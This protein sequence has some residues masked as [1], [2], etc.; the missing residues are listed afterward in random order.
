LELRIEPEVV[1]SLFEHESVSD[2]AVGDKEDILFVGSQE[3]EGFDA[4]LDFV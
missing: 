1:K 4:A 3:I 2:A